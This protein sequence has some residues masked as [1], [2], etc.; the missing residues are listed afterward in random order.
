M[1]QTDLFDCVR[2]C[3]A[4]ALDDR[5]LQACLQPCQPDPAA[6]STGTEL[7]APVA[8]GLACALVPF[9]AL[10]AGLT[11]GLLRLDVVGLRILEQAGEPWE[12]QCARA[13]LPIRCQG[14]L[15]LCTLLLGE[16]LC[17]RPESLCALI[18]CFNPHRHISSA[19]GNTVVNAAISILLA[20]LTTG[21]IGLLSSTTLILILGAPHDAFSLCLFE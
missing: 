5:T 8:I 13:I 10:F 14:N 11:L 4:K 6:L 21:W 15:L 7:S 16:L 9:T 18:K 17:L 19:P 1:A 3:T 20:D 2:S 12:R